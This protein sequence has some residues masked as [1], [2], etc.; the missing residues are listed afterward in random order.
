MISYEGKP[1]VLD[2]VNQLPYFFEGIWMHKYKGK[3]YLSYSTGP[4][5][6]GRGPQIAYAV[7]DSV[8][9][10]YQYKGVI[11]EEVS[12]GTNHSSIVEYKGQWY[13]FYHTSE[14]ALSLIPEGSPE[15]DFI[16]WRRSVCVAPLY[17]NEDGTVRPVEA[18]K[19]FKIVCGK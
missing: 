8:Y 16:Q 9:G 7:A 3:Y 4:N 5:I 15:R 11:L 18:K 14:R 2:N 19:S 10:P 1:V 13:L 6:P 12:S 17:Y